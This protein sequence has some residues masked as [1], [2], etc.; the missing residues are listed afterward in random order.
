MTLKGYENLDKPS[1]G[2]LSPENCVLSPTIK[3]TT[4]RLMS[5]S[6]PNIYKK[7]NTFNRSASNLTLN[8]RVSLGSICLIRPSSVVSNGNEDGPSNIPVNCCS[9]KCR[10][11]RTLL[12]LF[13]FVYMGYLVMGGILFHNIEHPVELQ[14]REAVSVLRNA[15]LLKYPKVNG[16]SENVKKM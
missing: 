16:K 6:D 13:V 12:L 8:T 3:P 15:F 9:S 1:T 2:R 7:P 11:E 4:Q 10:R 5:M 14:E